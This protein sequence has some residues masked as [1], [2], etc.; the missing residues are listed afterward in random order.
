[1][2]F[3]CLMKGLAEKG[4]LLGPLFWNEKKKPMAVGELD[5][6]FH[7]VLKEVWQKY[8]T[9]IPDSVNMEGDFSTSQSLRQGATSE[10]QNAGIHEDVINLNN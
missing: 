5:V 4:R 3:I 2:W 7:K 1:M 6:Y 8:L 9:I 10:A